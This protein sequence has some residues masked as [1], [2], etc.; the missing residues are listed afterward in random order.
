[1]DGYKRQFG[2]VNVDVQE[3]DTVAGQ[4]AYDYFAVEEV[5]V[6]ASP[7]RA[8]GD[9]PGQI[10]T[11]SLAEVDDPFNCHPEA[12]ARGCCHTPHPDAISA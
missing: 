9:L 2:A 6:I 5:K 4:C 12:L 8:R 1:M 3:P 10:E 7:D 11:W